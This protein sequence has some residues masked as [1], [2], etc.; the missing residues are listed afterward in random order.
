MISPDSWTIEWIRSV[1]EKYGIKDVGL[2]EKTIRAFC[3]LESLA[4][5]DCPFVFK[6]GSCLMLHFNTA[7]RLSIDIDIVCPP[8]TDIERYLDVH[9]GEYGFAKPMLVERKSRMHVPKSHAKF[10]Y[11]VAYSPIVQKDKILLDVLFEDVLYKRVERRAISSPLLK[12]EGDDVFVNIP[13]LTDILGDKLTAFAPQTTGIPFFKNGDSRSMEIVKQLFDIASIFDALEDFRDVFEVY[14]RI[15][16]VE[17][18][19]RGLSELSYAGVLADTINT[20]LNLATH[21]GVD[22]DSFLQLSEGISKV[23]GFI[24]S[25][26][27]TVDDAINDSA[28]IACLAASLQKGIGVIEKYDPSKKTEMLDAVIQAP[29]NTKLNKLKKTN[30]EAFYYWYKTGMLLENRKN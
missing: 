1:S 13:S 15:V 27:Y 14:Q 2:V 11:Q 9:A 21:G 7:K 16:N 19:Y 3:L 30:T 29:M 22:K 5:T 4:R 23:R 25:K 18:S 6:G 12:M 26:T 20:A 28:K 10:Y 17:L 24:H 8:G